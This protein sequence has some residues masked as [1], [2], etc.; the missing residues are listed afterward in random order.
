MEVRYKFEQVE[1]H[2]YKQAH[3]IRKIFQNRYELDE[4]VNEVW[5]RGKIQKLND[6]RFVAKRAYF[7]MVDYVRSIEGRHTMR[8]E[9]Y[10]A[11]KKGFIKKSLTNQHD[12]FKMS[13]PD[14]EQDFFN[15]LPYEGRTDTEVM[16]DK[17]QAEYILSCLPK[18]E[19]EVLRKYYFEE[20]NLKEIG[21]ELGVAEV[22]VSS[23]R[24]RAL[25]LTAIAA[26]LFKEYPNIL[27]D[28]KKNDSFNALMFSGRPPKK[29]KLEEIL[30]EYVADFEID[31][32]YSTSEEFVLEKDWEE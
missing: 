6:I 26:R 12:R 13:Y 1:K 21:K 27:R 4:L 23:T 8:G 28:Q 2:L 18:R 15:S 24:R 10:R 20:K 30:P 22:T 25:Q 14:M 31:N 29:D 17:E 9:N 19:A 11:P 16:I 5:V 3:K 32:E 7:D